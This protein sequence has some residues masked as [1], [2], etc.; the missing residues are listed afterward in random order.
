M[1]RKLII[2]AVLALFAI[3]SFVI[4]GEEA[5]KVEMKVMKGEPADFSGTLV[6]MGCSLKKSEAANSA[7]KEYGHR[8]AIM[9]DD[10]KYINLLE[11]KFSE[12]LISGEKYGMKKVTAHGVYHASANQ[13]DVE[14]FSVEGNKKVWCD[15]CTAMDGCMVKK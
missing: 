15:H 2:M 3:G 4:A 6:C 1:T 12:D 5:G 8:H 10:G 7:C 14:S 11:N 9:T 13:L